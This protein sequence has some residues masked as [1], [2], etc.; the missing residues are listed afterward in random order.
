MPYEIFTYYIFNNSKQ[1]Q[2]IKVK[3]R[4]Q[5][6]GLML[7]WA[8]K[9]YYYLQSIECHQWQLFEQSFFRTLEDHCQ[10]RYESLMS[11]LLGKCIHRTAAISLLQRW[12]VEWTS[13][14]GGKEN[15]F[16]IYIIELHNFGNS[17]SI[18][19]SI[20]RLDLVNTYDIP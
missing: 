20:Y 6:K 8:I 2:I 5:W 3:S 11:A 18:F 15:H 1:Y 12:S 4:Y 19:A 14:T 7:N 13:T 17:L 16:V 10:D 9:Y